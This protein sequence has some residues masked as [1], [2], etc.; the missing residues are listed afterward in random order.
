MTSAWSA[1]PTYSSQ[2]SNSRHR[3]SQITSVKR[4]SAGTIQ[5]AALLL[6]NPKASAACIKV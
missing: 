6:R 4:A 1:R 5:A 3:L 2:R